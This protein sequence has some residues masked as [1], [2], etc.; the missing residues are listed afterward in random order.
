[1]SSRLPPLNP[2][3]AFEAAARHGSVTAAAAELN[4]THG[5][6]SHQIRALEAS[7][8]VTLLERGGRRLKLTPHGAALLPSVSTAFDEIAS[9]TARMTRPS[10]EGD[11]AIS[12]VPALLSFW[13]LP[14]LNGFTALFP[15]IRLSLVASNDPVEIYG[16]T[17]D[18]SILYGDGP[19]TDCW[20]KPWVDLELFP[21]VSPTL[22]NAKPLRT[23]RDLAGHVL[24]HADDG[25]EWHTWLA[26]ADALDLERGPHHFMGDARLAIEGAICGNGVTLGDTMTASGL[27]GRGQLVAPFD[28]AVSAVNSFHV[29]CRAEAKA[30][31]IVQVFIDWL[32]AALDEDTARAQLQAPRR[33]RPAS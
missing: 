16:R 21:V 2:L 23:I 27:L 4:V 13:L 20:V 1:M 3:R 11:L 33:R 17:V 24:L 10:T 30:A 31:P 15:G 19:W 26:S 14:R 5:A 28:L 8:K 7:L 18:V 29:A 6:I 9:A 22:V 25:R 32:Y 12:C